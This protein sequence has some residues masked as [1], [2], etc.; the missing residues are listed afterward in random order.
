MSDAAAQ[1]SALLAEKARRE[2]VR[3]EEESARAAEVAAEEAREQVA[4]AELQARWTKTAAGIRGTLYDKQKAA[5]VDEKA[6][7]VAM[8]CTRR[9]GK[10]FGGIRE[11]V[12]FAI[13][14]PRSRQL[15]INETR[16][17]AKA[18][19][20]DEPDDGILAV[21]NAFEF[22]RGDKRGDDADYW[23]NETELIVRF[24]NGSIIKLF[25]A[26]D[27]RQINK[28]RGRKWMRVL[29]D[30][31]QKARHLQQGIQQ[32]L[33]ASMAD[34]EGQI[35]I[36]GTP[37][38][39]TA[40]Y[41]FEVTRDDGQPAAPGWAVHRWSVVDNPFFGATP[42]E[43]WARTAGAAL[44]DNGWTEEEPDFRREWLGLWVLTDANFV[45]PVHAVDPRKLTLAPMRIDTSGLYDHEASLRDLPRNSRGK[46]QQWL[47]SIGV[48]F[49]YDPDGFAIVLIAFSMT[50]ETAFEM[51]SWKKTKTDVVEQKERL[52]YLFANVDGIVS[53]VGDPAGTRSLLK[54]WRERLGLPIEEA[55]KQEKDTWIDLIGADI[56]RG[57]FKYRSNSPL[58]DE[59]KHLVWL[60]IKNGKRVAH[61]HRKLLDGRVP[62][63]HCF[64]AGT[65]IETEHGP[66]PIESLRPG[67]RVWTRQG[68][69]PIAMT[70]QTGIEPVWRLET[71]NGSVLEGTRGHRIWTDAGWKELG[72]L[73][74]GITVTAWQSAANTDRPRSSSSTESS[75]AATR[76]PSAETFGPT[77]RRGEADAH[78]ACTVRS[79]KP[80]MARFLTAITSIISTAI[81]S[82]TSS[83]TWLLSRAASIIAS[84]CASGWPQPSFA[85]ASN[86]RWPRRAS[87]PRNGT[88]Q[89]L[90]AS[91]TASTVEMSLQSERL[92]SHGLTG[93]ASSALEP[94]RVS[95]A[96]TCAAT[97]A[98][99]S[100]AGTVASMTST[101]PAASAGARSGAT[102][103]ASPSTAHDR[104]SLVTPTGLALPV[105]NLAV[106]G[107]HEYF[108]NG[109]LVANCSDAA[110]YGWRHAANWLARPDVGPRTAEETMQAEESH[111][112][113]QVDRVAE[114]DDD[115][116]RFGVLDEYGY[117]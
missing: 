31:A 58:L 79:G 15:Y 84:T 39:D 44:K 10:T 6:N 95:T 65:V 13:E 90:V 14:N 53:I 17:E 112:E 30:E 106:E 49:G 114:Q 88:A 42:E 51:Y 18:L 55:D 23:A 48:D 29:W 107:V 77:T 73:I 27:E 28:L 97:S 3:A 71:K 43:R 52:D 81:R 40:G 115:D 8:L 19:A 63:D 2:R 11:M 74:P 105:Y 64:I 78:S 103:T 69:R 16:D 83:T 72:S 21:L 104:V 33:G 22:K 87:P 98:S 32:V 60:P 76:S 46:V 36:T 111:Y 116:D 20:W 85:T 54:G 99:P 47:F 37:S 80:R 113:Q 38:L 91:G 86:H 50:C 45:Y 25:G 70:G 75:T 102:G 100:N 7:R 4:H 68:L 35:W 61:K 89:M 12:A 108:A 117:G 9:A 24:R 67:V 110:L 94:S 66:R 96:R 34:F 59:H 62:G 109:I 57:K 92:A 56:R 101:S 26:D 1:L 5:F 82:T 93:P 41:F